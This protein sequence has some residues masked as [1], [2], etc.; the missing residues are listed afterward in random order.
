MKFEFFGKN[1]GEYFPGPNRGRYICVDSTVLAHTVDVRNLT[2]SLRHLAPRGTQ[3]Y[4]ND[5]PGEDY[6]VTP[7]N[8][9]NA[10][11]YFQYDGPRRFYDRLMVELESTLTD[12]GVLN[13]M[14]EIK[15]VW[16]AAL[17]FPIAPE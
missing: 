4:V 17:S 1:F 3:D 12:V 6:H 8:S 10:A 5:P 15:E 2:E 14:G 9:I 7:F 13:N 16:R 11:L